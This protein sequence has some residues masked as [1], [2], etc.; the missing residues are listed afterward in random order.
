MGKYLWSSVA[1]VFRNGR[2]SKVSRAVAYTVKVTLSKKWCKIDTYVVTTNRRH[3]DQR[4]A[5]RVAAVVVAAAAAAAAA[6]IQRQA[7]ALP[8]RRIA[9]R[10]CRPERRHTARSLFTPGHF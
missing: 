4:L 8:A 1:S 2:L 7:A 3:I 10:Y 9:A 6:G 5:C